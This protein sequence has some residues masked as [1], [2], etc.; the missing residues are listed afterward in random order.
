MCGRENTQLIFINREWKSVEIETTEE[1]ERESL[2]E[3]AVF[4]IAFFPLS[5]VA[6]PTDKN[7]PTRKIDSLKS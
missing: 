7:S 6:F 4:L 2:R 5:P 1:R 3:N